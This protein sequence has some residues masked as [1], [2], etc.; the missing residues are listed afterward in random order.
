MLILSEFI[1]RGS[2]EEFY[3]MLENLKDK[4]PVM[5]IKKQIGKEIVEMISLRTDTPQEKVRDI[6]GRWEDYFNFWFDMRCPY[7]RMKI[8]PEALGI[9]LSDANIIKAWHLFIKGG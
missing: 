1:P 5:E 7:C 4:F 6:I 3:E 2:S 9:E 8:T